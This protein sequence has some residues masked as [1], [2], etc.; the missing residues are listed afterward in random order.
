MRIP[1][2]KKVK[3]QVVFSTTETPGKGA[4]HWTGN[5]IVDNLKKRNLSRDFYALGGVV[6]ELH[7][8]IVSKCCQALIGCQK[9]TNTWYAEGEE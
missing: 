6:V 8:F 9:C 4:R 1:Q 3:I 7:S 2:V 5:V